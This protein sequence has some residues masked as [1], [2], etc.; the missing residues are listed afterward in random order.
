MSLLKA[1]RT[2]ILT[3][4]ECELGAD[5]RGALVALIKAGTLAQ[6]GMDTVE[7]AAE[8]GKGKKGVLYKEFVDFSQVSFVWLLGD[9]YAYLG[10]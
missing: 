4:T 1:A 3:A 8:S 10:W 7:Y 2:L 5:W 9:S 6:M